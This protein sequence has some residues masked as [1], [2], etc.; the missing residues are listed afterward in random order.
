MFQ[1]KA[2]R[3]KKAFFNEQ[4]IKLEEDNRREKTRYLFWKAGNIKMG[5]IK[6]RNSRDLVD[7]EKIN[8]RWKEYMEELYKKYLFELDYYD[9][10][11]SHSEPDILE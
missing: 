10:V 4:C 1:R 8:K 5:I 9:S 2:W 7:T 3:E 11:V 6:D